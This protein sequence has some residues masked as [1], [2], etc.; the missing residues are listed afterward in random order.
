MAPLPQNNTHRL[1][2]DY[3]TGDLATSQEHTLAIRY[4]PSLRDVGDVQ[5]DL[6]AVLNAFT[7]PAFR[8]GWKVTATRV[9]AAGSNF[10]LPVATISGL[11]GFVGTGGGAYFPRHETVEETFQGRSSTSGRRVDLSLY[12]AAG[13]VSENFRVVGGPS[14]LFLLVRL[15]AAA[16]SAASAAG[17]FLAIDGSQAVWRDYMNQNY[18]S[19]W[20]RRVRTV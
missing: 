3:V 11:A 15:V 7:A 20:E 1:F 12:R 2:V 6:L 5:G 9:Q 14:G 4:N 16:L 18:N 19:Y 8:T 17:S 10:S 13:D